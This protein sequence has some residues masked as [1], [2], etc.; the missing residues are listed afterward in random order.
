MPRP[1]AKK[2]ANPV[3]TAMIAA[4][5]PLSRKT[6]SPSKSS[7]TVETAAGR[8]GST[9]PSQRT[10][11]SSP[12]TQAQPLIL[13]TDGDGTPASFSAEVSEPFHSASPPD[14]VGVEIPILGPK[15]SPHR[16]AT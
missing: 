8:I 14:G 9:F 6:S 10:Q 15:R 5:N 4:A 16:Q 2:S 3:S 1:A 11:L 13:I 7:R 12:K